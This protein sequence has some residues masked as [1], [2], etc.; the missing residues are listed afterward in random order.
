MGSSMA[1]FSEEQLRQEVAGIRWFHQID[2][3]H[4]VVTPGH[5]RSAEKLPRIG[6][7]ADL[8]GK[9]VLDVGAWDGFFSFE[10]ERR[11]AERV[12]AI[13]PNAWRAPVEPD[14][15]WSGQEGFKLARR[16]LGSNVEDVDMSLEE[17]SP[18]RIGRFDI[19][20][21][22]GVFYHLPDPLPILERVASVT[23]ERLIV[24][25]QADLL[26]LRRPAMAYYP[27]SELSHDESNWW[28]PNL[29][30]LRALLRSHG[31]PAVELV[32]RRS[33][34]YRAARSIRW[35]LK[36]EPILAQQDRLV[37]HGLR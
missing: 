18:E 22:L 5:D 23:A 17:L 19:V 11:G 15:P 36:G 27:G 37:V 6:I 10:A 8:T 12:V 1:P 4:G 32:S 34:P 25:T 16:V 3:G 21:F 26:W 29:P 7:P 31:F 35:R 33:L 20:L 14:N 28:A 13:D 2:L 30:L 24:E 9:T